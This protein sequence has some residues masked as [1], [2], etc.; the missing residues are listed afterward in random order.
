MYTLYI[1][2]QLVYSP[3]NFNN[4]VIV[5]RNLYDLHMIPFRIRIVSVVANTTTMNS[6]YNT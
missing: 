3:T 6:T 1:W 4:V 5:L 2:G